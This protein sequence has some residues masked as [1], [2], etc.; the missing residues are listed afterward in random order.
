MYF[1]TKIKSL[2]YQF[3]VQRDMGLQMEVIGLS[4]AV[5]P[6]WWLLVIEFRLSGKLAWQQIPLLAEPIH[7]PQ[8]IILMRITICMM[9]LWLQTKAI[10]EHIC[11]NYF[12]DELINGNLF[13]SC[14]QKAFT[15]SISSY[16]SQRLY[17]SEIFIVLFQCNCFLKYILCTL[18]GTSLQ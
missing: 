5:L 4:K 6:V 16:F 2:S 17:L 14:S 3:C 8:N 13:I 1:I 10:M 11:G 12:L 18:K 7:W 9:W 15:F